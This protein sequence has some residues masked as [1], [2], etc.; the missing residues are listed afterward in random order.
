MKNS[1]RN[2]KLWE[3]HRLYY[4]EMRDLI[5]EGQKEKVNKPE[6]SEER[7]NIFDETVRYAL[8]FNRPVLVRYYSE[9]Q[10]KEC[11]VFSFKLDAEEMVCENGKKIKCSDILDIDLC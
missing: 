9:E 6:I 7:L 2:N 1:L 5:V 8:N 4:P 10:I 3:G 11:V